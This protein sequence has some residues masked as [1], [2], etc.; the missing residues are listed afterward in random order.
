MS[1]SGSSAIEATAAALA[2]ALDAEDFD[3]ARPLLAADCVYET[4]AATLHG[5]DPILA[6]YAQASTWARRTFDEVRYASD[7]DP[8]D[9]DT[10]TVTYTDYLLKAGG[11]WHRYRCQQVLTVGPEARI[12]RIVHRELPGEREALEAYFRECGVER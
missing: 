9:G 12:T 6:S 4:G 7:V 1:G 8:A 11:R 5:P 2:R 10:V 3:T